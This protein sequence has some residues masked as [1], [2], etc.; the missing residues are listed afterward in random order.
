MVKTRENRGEKPKQS[1]SHHPISSTV[2]NISITSR[3][4]F[5]AYYIS[6]Q[7]LGSQESIASN[8]DRFGVETKKLWPF[9]DKPRK[10]KAGIF[11]ISQP[12]PQFEGCFAAAKPP[13]GTRVPLRSVVHPF[14]SCEIGCEIPHLLH[15]R[16]NPPPPQNPPP[17]AK[18]LQA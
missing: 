12:H 11:F 17:S 5:Q 18:M 3:S 9:E 1:N 8:S 15:S 6:F 2:G 13:F 16:E 10:A 14:R 4:S 7:S